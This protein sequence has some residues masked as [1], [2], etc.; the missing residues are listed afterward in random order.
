MSQIIAEIP[1]P[2][3]RVSRVLSSVV[4]EIVNLDNTTGKVH[5]KDLKSYSVT[6]SG[7]D[8]ILVV[9]EIIV[10]GSISSSRDDGF[11]LLF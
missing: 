1:G 2:S 4:D 9:I 6:V 11:F 7:F 10:Q 3:L 8:Q 5:I